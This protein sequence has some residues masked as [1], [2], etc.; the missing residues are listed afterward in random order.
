MPPTVANN[1]LDALSSILPHLVS[2]LFGIQICPDDPDYPVPAR[3]LTNSS[4]TDVLVPL[5]QRIT[6]N[7]QLTRLSAPSLPF[8][9]HTTPLPSHSLPLPLLL[10]AT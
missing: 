9:L 10:P 7:H 5:M 8:P 4:H 1:D 3:S 6:W 2:R